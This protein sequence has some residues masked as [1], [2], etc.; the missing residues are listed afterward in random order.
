MKLGELKVRKD[1]SKKMDVD[2]KA[3]GPAGVVTYPCVTVYGCR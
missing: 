3:G 1:L 2:H